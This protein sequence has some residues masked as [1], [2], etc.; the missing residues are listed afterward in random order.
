MPQDFAPPNGRY[1]RE[2]FNPENPSAGAM[3]VP[4]FGGQSAVGPVKQLKFGMFI[5]WP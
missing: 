2:I 3:M 5:L 4:G 1:F